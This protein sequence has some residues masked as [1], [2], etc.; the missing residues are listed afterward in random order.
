VGAR[1]SALLDCN[2]L[3]LAVVILR[4]SM[5]GELDAQLLDIFNH[6]S[7]GRSRLSALQSC[8][9]EPTE[10]GTLEI[11]H[12]DMLL[13]CTLE[14][15]AGLADHERW[16]ARRA[17]WRHGRYPRPGLAENTQA[18]LRRAHTQ[19]LECKATGCGALVDLQAARRLARKA[20]RDYFIAGD[21][22][23]SAQCSTRHWPARFA[24]G[25]QR[26]A[27]ALQS[28]ERRLVLWP[29]TTAAR[30]EIW[31]LPAECGHAKARATLATTRTCDTRKRRPKGPLA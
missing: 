11:W 30:S 13:E 21:G 6:N 8:D 18:A 17:C 25:Q 16:T 3:G 10:H 1:E 12:G 15:R 23:A 31:A 20:G 4:S 28:N 7:A 29:L 9:G 22:C 5:A 2:S 26:M 19:T 14:P 24:A 27:A